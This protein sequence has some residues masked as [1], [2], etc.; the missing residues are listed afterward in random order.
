MSKI[1]TTRMENQSSQDS[2]SGNCKTIKGQIIQRRRPRVDILRDG[3]I[4]GSQDQLRSLS[5]DNRTYP[6]KKM[7][8]KN[9]ERVAIH[10]VGMKLM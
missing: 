5:R 1:K 10:A 4:T 2:S 3:S 7:K 9:V 8:K 6:K